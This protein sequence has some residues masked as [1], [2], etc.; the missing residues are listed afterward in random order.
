MQLKTDQVHVENPVP[1]MQSVPNHPEKTNGWSCSFQQW[2]PHQLN[3]ACLLNSCRLW[4]GAVTVR[5]LAGVQHPWWTLNGCDLTLPTEI[6][7]SE[8]EYS[9]L[10]RQKL[11]PSDPIL[12]F[13]KVGKT[14]VDIFGIL[15][16]YL[17]SFVESENQV[18]CATVRMKT[19][20]GIIQLC[21]N[22]LVASLFK[23]L[24]IWLF[25]SLRRFSRLSHRCI[26]THQVTMFISIYF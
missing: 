7:M 10:D 2:H 14:C 5:T 6:Q 18:W 23:T 11:F 1:K 17:E 12:C 22:Y 21:L 26:K 19:A 9:D 24:G 15:P 4:R 20:L 16:R 8:K 13:L 3:C 25:L